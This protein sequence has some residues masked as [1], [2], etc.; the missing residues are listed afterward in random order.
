[1]TINISFRQVFILITVVWI[2]LRIFFNV[3]RKKTDRKYECKLITVYI[4]I[5][6]ITRIV[7]FL[8]AAI[9]KRHG[10]ERK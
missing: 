1:M 5:I 4:C 2:L 10:N 6:V 9:R 8:I 3:K 7:Y